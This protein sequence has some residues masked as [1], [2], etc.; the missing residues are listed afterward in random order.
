[1]EKTLEKSV[2]QSSERLKNSSLSSSPVE[3]SDSSTD[4]S[5]E[6]SS[7]RLKKPSFSCPKKGT[8]DSSITFGPEDMQMFWSISEKQDFSPLKIDHLLIE[9]SF[10]LNSLRIPLFCYIFYDGVWFMKASYKPKI[11]S[12]A[13]GGSSGKSSNDTQSTSFDALLT[14]VQDIK[15]SLVTWGSSR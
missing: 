11:K 1:M 4:D 3:I 2:H 10:E 14:K 9:E 13:V 5:P 12:S 7:S 6:S 15:L 8:I